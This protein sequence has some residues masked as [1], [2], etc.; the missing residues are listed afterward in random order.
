[1]GRMSELAA[2]QDARQEQEQAEQQSYLWHCMTELKP[3]LS[4]A[5][6]QQVE[7]EMGFGPK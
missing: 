6:Y 1:M 3:H 2:E 7:Q 4:D 5:L